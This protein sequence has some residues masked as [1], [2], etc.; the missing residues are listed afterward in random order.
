MPTPQVL[1]GGSNV[2]G[3]GGGVAGNGFGGDRASAYN[4]R[5]NRARTATMAQRKSVGGGGVIAMNNDRFDR[6]T[7]PR[8]QPLTLQQAPPIDA[9]AKEVE[10]MEMDEQ[11]QRQQTQALRQQNEQYSSGRTDRPPAAQYGNRGGQAASYDDD[12][13]DIGDDGPSYGSMVPQ[14]RQPQRDDNYGSSS[15]RRGSNNDNRDRGNYRD[16]APPRNRDNRQNNNNRG[17][18]N[19]PDNSDSD[20]DDRPPPQSSSSSRQRQ[21]SE[22]GGGGGQLARVERPMDNMAPA[23]I[24]TSD[25]RAFLLRP[26]PQGAMVQCYIQ[27]RKTGLARLYPT[28]EVYLKDGEQFLLAARRRKKQ[29]QSNYKVS[30]DREDLSRHSSNYFGKLKSNFMGTE[31]QV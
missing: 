21:Q 23:V 1:S 15:S 27:R 14:S 12:A 2:G 16:E 9:L 5:M 24:D 11:D 22:N 7:T 8:S 10:E 20:D 17:R 19:N 30:L 28:Y 4:E 6:P 3:N 25:L 26:G 31:F 18:N 13:V 29:K